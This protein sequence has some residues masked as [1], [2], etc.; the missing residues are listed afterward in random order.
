MSTH[1]E[2]D[3]WLLPRQ[4]TEYPARA[5]LPETTLHGRREA[6]FLVLTALF[7]VATTVLVVLGFT[8][9]IDL[10]A[11]LARISPAATPPLALVVPLGVL[12]F[13]L[14]FVA[15]ALLCELLGRRRAAAAILIGL[16]INVA[17]VGLMQAADL[18]DGGDAVTA[19]AALAATSIVAHLAHLLVFDLLRR[20]TPGRQLFARMIISSWLALALGLGTCALV[21]GGGYLITPLATEPL[22]ALVLGSAIAL[23]ACTLVLAIPAALIGR[24]LAVALRVGPSW[25]AHDDFADQDEADAEPAWGAPRPAFAE[26]SVARTLPRAQIVEEPSVSDGVPRRARAMSVP[27][28][29]S[30]EM[31][32]FSEGDEEQPA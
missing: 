28:Y 23:A 7:F 6:T 26:G 12:P 11:L 8:R 29:S 13:A 15:S 25:F 4:Q 9:T 27:P 21:L 2:R 5:L 32:F 3:R 20:A 18:V 19:G 14:S 24:G 30:A 31:R 10:T 22:Q 17:L 1:N 16:V